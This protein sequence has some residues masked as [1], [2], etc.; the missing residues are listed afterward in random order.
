MPLWNM[1]FK[2]SQNKWKQNMLSL[3]LLNQ[4]ILKYRVPSPLKGIHELCKSH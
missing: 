1:G 4:Q 2:K 3:Q